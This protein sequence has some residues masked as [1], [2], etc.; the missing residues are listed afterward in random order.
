MLVV[1]RHMGIS[2]AMGVGIRMPRMRDGGVG[3]ATWL[4]IRGRACGAVDVRTEVGWC[5][6]GW[7]CPIVER[8]V[9]AVPV[10]G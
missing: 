6:F 9:R 1:V 4:S 7:Y 8:E 3:Y 10:E 2:W 5:Q